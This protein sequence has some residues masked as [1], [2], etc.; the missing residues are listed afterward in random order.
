[1]MGDRYSTGPLYNA[2]MARKKAEQDSLL[3]ANRI[4]LLRAEEEKT[5]Q[6][7][8]DTEKKTQEIVDLRRRN[9]E[10]RLAKEAE[11]AQ[12]EAEEQE[13]RVRQMYERVGHH[14]KLADRQRLVA[15]RKA[16]V[17]RSVRQ[18]REVHKA[19]IEEQRDEASAEALARADRVRNAVAAA[20]RSRAKSES[21]KQELGKMVVH[22]RLVREEDERRARLTEINRM[23]REEAELIQRLQR[24]QERHR[25]AFM[26]LEDVLRGGMLSSTAGTSTPSS[27]GLRP[28]PGSSSSTGA[29]RSD[30]DVQSYSG[31]VSSAS[32]RPPRPRRPPIGGPLPSSNLS[33]SRTEPSVSKESAVVTPTSASNLELRPKQSLS[34]M[35]SCSTA[36]GPETGRGAG[37]GHS[38]PNS[39]SATQIMY[40]RVDGVQL[41]IPMEEDLDLAVLLNS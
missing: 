10:R 33:T 8:R 37:S 11:E 12:K 25:A 9:E 21:A 39:Q 3:L 1:M 34:A 19:V 40:T 2:I 29:L 28:R 30:R 7:I 23:E 26:Q 35:S 22:E 32:S 16:D 36:S 4:R 31:A 18:D 41:E 14:Q 13:L 15:E 27:E 6:K 5:R 17:S 20:S 38:T 24:T